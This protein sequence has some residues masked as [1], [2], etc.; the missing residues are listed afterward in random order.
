MHLLS[1]DAVAAGLVWQE[2]FFTQLGKTASWETR[3][4]LGCAIWMAYVADRLFDSLSLDSKK[5]R[6]KRHRFIKTHWLVFLSIWVVIFSS[7]TP[8]AY[9]NLSQEHF[10]G[11]LW[12]MV[13]VN[14]YF[15][16]LKFSKR[17]AILGSLKEILT[18]TLFS[19]GVSFFPILALTEIS[20]ATI[21]LQ[22]SFGLLCVFNVFLIS[23][24][25][26]RIDQ[27]QK[28]S[29]LSQHGLDRHV[30]LMIMISVNLISGVTMSLLD[31]GIF[32]S[33]LLISTSAITCLHIY[34]TKHG[35][36]NLK[37]LI[38]VP[39]MLPLFLIFFF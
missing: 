23:H 1:L 36:G 34:T 19:L 27:G 39:L 5:P 24:W 25:E 29:N 13:L 15:I 11:G 14:L 2:V 31:F 18:G 16:L 3:L 38:D 7:I 17:I 9:F 26:F 37:P 12:I 22:A 28:E 4:I 35:S 8:F 21:I 20:L 30:I 33:S 32:S 6:T 10:I